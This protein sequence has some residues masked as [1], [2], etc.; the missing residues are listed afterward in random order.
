MQRYDFYLKI[1]SFG[2]FLWYIMEELM[3]I[4]IVGSEKK[5][6]FSNPSLMCFTVESPLTE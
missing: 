1:Q 5:I 4:R 6:T 3:Q 2:R